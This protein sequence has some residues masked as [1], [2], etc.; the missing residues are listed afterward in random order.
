[1]NLQ[2][3]PPADQTDPQALELEQ[4][5]AS[6]TLDQL[7][8]LREQGMAPLEPTPAL[9]HEA[10][11][12]PFFERHRLAYFDTFI[13]R[14]IGTDAARLVNLVMHVSGGH[15]AYLGNT[16]FLKMFG[17][18]RSR[19]DSA[20]RAAREAGLLIEWQTRTGDRR[21][22]M[23]VDG[24][25]FER[26]RLEEC[27]A[28][29]DEVRDTPALG[30]VLRPFEVFAEPPAA[31]VD[32]SPE[33]KGKPLRQNDAM[34]PNIGLTIA[35]NHSIHCVEIQQSEV[36]ESKQSQNPARAH[37]S[38]TTQPPVVDDGSREPG[39]DDE[40]SPP[41][42]PAASDSSTEMLEAFCET[43][44]VKH[45]AAV[46]ALFC[47]GQQVTVPEAAQL[48]A[49]AHQYNGDGTR[50]PIQSWKWF[51]AEL[52]KL[53]SRG[54]TGLTPVG[55]HADWATTRQV[56]ASQDAALD[57]RPTPEKQAEHMAAISGF[58]RSKSKAFS[59]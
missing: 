38:D 4:F 59:K 36:E 11:L 9:P 49:N 45:K 28:A 15:E 23:R 48:I 13:D 27:R 20:R 47:G 7:T 54:R 6:L 8:T 52:T 31:P 43:N 25:A 26:I 12:F 34:A 39:S 56:L 55:G 40:A 42:A 1:M 14:R 5:R 41:P 53:R 44:G 22:R 24:A 32:N 21:T 30:W 37:A 18:A 3:T 35:S 51:E 17:W 10:A 16:Y 46:I 58:L 29:F 19:Y 33:N 2:Q 57:H 50:E